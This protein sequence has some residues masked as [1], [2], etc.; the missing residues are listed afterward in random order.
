M[1][2]VEGAVGE[3]DALIVFVQV[4]ADFEK[5]LESEFVVFAEH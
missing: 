1:K 5:S 4:V 2:H 3:G